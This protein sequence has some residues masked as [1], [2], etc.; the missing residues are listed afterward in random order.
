MSPS[1]KDMMLPKI[2]DSRERNY[3][4]TLQLNNS[5]NYYYNII[6]T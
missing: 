2:T 6:K 4:N 1:S 5:E 3:Q